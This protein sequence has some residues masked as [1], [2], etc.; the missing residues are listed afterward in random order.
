VRRQLIT[1]VAAVT[2]MVL[3][4]FLIPLGYLVALTTEDRAVRGAILELDTLRSVV[5]T[6][7]PE[8]IGL[9]V[10]FLNSQRIRRTTVRLGDGTV[11][12]VAKP[13]SPAERLAGARG[14]TVDAEAL[15]GGREIAA[16][17][18]GRPEGLAVI[19]VVITADQLRQG[20]L[21]AWGILGALGLGLFVLAIVV[22]DRLARHIVGPTVELAA[23][24]ARLEAGDLETRVTPAG[25]PET[26]EVGH[27]LNRLAARIG[28]LLSREREA[29]ADL[30]HRLRT[31]VAALRLDAEGLTDADE[32]ARLTDDV[33][34]LERMVDDVIHEARRPVREGAGGGCEAV[35][36]VRERVEF[37]RVLAEDQDRRMQVRLPEERAQVAVSAQDLAA[38]VDVM[39]GNVFSHTEE[40]VPFRVTVE[41]GTGCVA[42]I[43]S[44]SGTGFPG[45][46]VLQRGRSGGGSTGLGLDIARRTAEASGGRLLIARSGTGGAEIT[47]ELGTVPAH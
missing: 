41:V 19:S 24:A 32:R 25:P 15:E 29:V 3:L 22:A 30:S 9:A 20:V 14:S 4:A 12:G 8:A 40:G 44:D 23:A 45:R 11:L 38:A 17:V 39:L 33:D 46:E 16:P 21:R 7:T 42:V 47:L 5:G 10:D 2:S 6:Q 35:S 13:P 1:T 36:V 31:P 37:W 28:E 43:V 34:A 26:T 27:A 18:E